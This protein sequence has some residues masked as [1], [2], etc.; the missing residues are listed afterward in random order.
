[1]EVRHRE[2][3]DRGR[4][5]PGIDRSAEHARR[6]DT[7]TAQTSDEGQRLATAARGQSGIARSDESTSSNHALGI[8]GDGRAI[9][10]RLKREFK[11]GDQAIG[12]AGDIRGVG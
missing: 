10:H 12:E 11:C 4:K 9:L 5:I 6:D 3:N 7:I 8:R 2:P 1:M